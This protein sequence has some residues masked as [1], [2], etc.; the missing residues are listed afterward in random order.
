MKMINKNTEKDK[1]DP[2]YN[3]S[4]IIKYYSIKYIKCFK[5]LLSGTMW[6]FW[7]KVYFKSWR[8]P[9]NLF[10]LNQF[11]NW[12][13]SVPLIGQKNFSAQ[14]AMRSSQVTLSPSYEGCPMHPTRV[15][16]SLVFAIRQTGN[17][18]V[19]PIPSNRHESFPF[20]RFDMP[21]VDSRES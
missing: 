1:K 19:N 7:A 20:C 14:L 12:S 15:D 13:N 5:I 8:A 4:K 9:G 16:S 2:S 18:F 17:Q 21:E 6:Y 3:V 11:Q 10:L